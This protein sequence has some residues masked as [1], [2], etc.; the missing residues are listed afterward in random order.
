[1]CEKEANDQDFMA[2]A[3]NNG[4]QSRFELG[5]EFLRKRILLLHPGNEA[6]K[7]VFL[8]ILPSFLNQHHCVQHADQ[9]REILSYCLI[10]PAFNQGERKILDTLVFNISKSPNV[11]TA[12][13]AVVASDSGNMHENHTTNGFNSYDWGQNPIADAANLTAAGAPSNDNYAAQAAAAAAA[14]AANHINQQQR[15]QQQQQN[16][17]NYHNMHSVRNQSILVQQQQQDQ[18]NTFHAA[19]QILNQQQQQQQQQT[20]GVVKQQNG[21]SPM[22]PTGFFADVQVWLKSLR[23]HKY[24]DLFAEMSYDEMME[25]TPEKLDQKNVTKGARNKIILSIKR[26]RDRFTVL[27]NLEKDIMGGGSLRTALLELKNMIHT[28]IK[29]YESNDNNLFNDGSATS[30]AKDDISE[31]DIPSQYTK[32]MGK[33]CTQ[34]LVSKI[35]EENISIYFRLLDRCIAHPSFTEVQKRRLRS[36]RQQTQKMHRT[37]TRG[38]RPLTGAKLKPR[39]FD[40]GSNGGGQP[41][42]NQNQQLDPHNL[43]RHQGGLNNYQAMQQQQQQQQQSRSIGGR[44]QFAPHSSNSAPRQMNLMSSPGMRQMDIQ[45]H[46]TQQIWYNSNG[47]VQNSTPSMESMA[48]RRA[49]SLDPR[50]GTRM[51]GMEDDTPNNEIN[52]RLDSLC[53]SVAEHALSGV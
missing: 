2:R 29:H 31:D 30:S 14:A 12:A 36:W 37:M 8:S 18:Q 5:I 33:A 22:E 35:D 40:R 46:Q 48:S 16:R 13:A 21:G 25:L 1:M 17:N 15:D 45:Y 11:A 53:L 6:P 42:Q 20:N 49:A 3:M 26:L 41:P 50:L 24:A 28:P 43:N 44:T 52:T 23:L 10:H 39:K 51:F 34:I 47:G 7:K 38:I 9:T 19:Q 4:L 27:Q 32:V